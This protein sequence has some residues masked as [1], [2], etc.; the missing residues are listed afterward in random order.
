[1]ATPPNTLGPEYENAVSQ[2][3]PPLASAPAA[4][5]TVDFFRKVECDVDPVNIYGL[6]VRPR[7]QSLWGHKFALMQSETATDIRFSPRNYPLFDGVIYKECGAMHP[8]FNAAHRHYGI[9]APLRRNLAILRNYLMAHYPPSGEH[10]A[11]HQKLL[12]LMATQLGAAFKSSGKLPWR[13]WL[14][15]TFLRM[16]AGQK[17]AGREYTG[18]LELAAI[19]DRGVSFMY[20]YLRV[21]MDTPAFQNAIPGEQWPKD[22]M[23]LPLTQTPFSG[24]N[25]L[26]HSDAVQMQQIADALE[27]VAKNFRKVDEMHETDRAISVQHARDILNNMR[28]L[29]TGLQ[30]EKT[31]DSVDRRMADAHDMLQVGLSFK[32]EMAEVAKSDPQLLNNPVIQQATASISKAS[33]YVRSETKTV[34]KE[35]K[36][37]PP[38][39]KKQE[40]RRPEQQQQQSFFNRIQNS[41]RKRRTSPLIQMASR[42]EEG[43]H[44]AEEAR[45]A[46]NALRAK[47]KEKSMVQAPKSSEVGVSLSSLKV[48][49]H[50]AV[51]DGQSMMSSSKIQQVS[52]GDREFMNS[53][54]QVNEHQEK[55]RE[56]Q[57]VHVPV[58][59]KP[60]TGRT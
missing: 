13:T 43:L 12:A 6:V 55:L 41:Y 9:Y 59:T 5:P 58:H 57:A 38:E 15:L 47:R 40:E 20:H 54:K 51:K 33:S 45:R 56:Q 42:I 39:E 34:A 27:N 1:M 17:R 7:E 14:Y 3:L 18:F 10:A 2:G 19:A 8:A 28:I 36:Q 4:S 37:R 53:V 44:H 22:W 23:L 52:L 26:L 32:G 46:Q 29:A 48:D 35:T 60:G 16:I 25:I 30:E 50:N 24:E 31:H 11:F 21:L 49:V